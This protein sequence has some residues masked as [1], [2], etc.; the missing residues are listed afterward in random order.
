[1]EQEGKKPR[2]GIVNLEKRRYPRFTVDLPVEYLQIDSSTPSTGRL[3]NASE[4]GLLVYLPERVAV[5]QHLKMKIYF[6]FGSDLN[7]V[8]IR[9]EVVWEDI[10]LGKDWGDYRFGVRFTDISQDDLN[11]LKDF[12]RNLSA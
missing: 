6:S 1:M 5:G 2:I 9:A 8:E 12:L 10:H 7:T 11:K 4:G 3:I